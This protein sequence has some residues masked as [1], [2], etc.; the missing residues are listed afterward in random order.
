M[1][2][3]QDRS[4][5]A[6]KRYQPL[7]YHGAVKFVKAEESLRFPDNPEKVWSKLV[8][9]F[10]VSTVPGYHHEML[11]KSAEPLASLLSRYLQEVG[12]PE[13]IRG[14]SR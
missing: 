12:G 4:K 6:L 5:L 1:Q 2:K 13:S 8:D 3:V 11:T 7:H 9:Q 14:T 10:E